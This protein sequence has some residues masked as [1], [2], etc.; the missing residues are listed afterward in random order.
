[1]RRSTKGTFM[2]MQ[3]QK[4]FEINQRLQY[5]SADLKKVVS[6]YLSKGNAR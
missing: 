1:M 5:G 6:G 4:T 2:V 3:L